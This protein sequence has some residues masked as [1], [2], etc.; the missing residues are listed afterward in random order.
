[1]QREIEK[2]KKD[3]DILLKSKTD[4]NQKELDQ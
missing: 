4:A 3:N 1:M 2:L